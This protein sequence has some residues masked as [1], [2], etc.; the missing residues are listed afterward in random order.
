MTNYEERID[1]KKIQQKSKSTQPCIFAFE[2]ANSTIFIEKRKKHVISHTTDP[3]IDWA[4][5]YNDA[6]D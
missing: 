1:E 3:M 2:T 5:L 6:I 4:H